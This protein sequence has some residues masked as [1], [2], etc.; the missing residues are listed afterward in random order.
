MA[1]D[2]GIQIDR[3]TD[4]DR[5]TETDRYRLRHRQTERDPPHNRPTVLINKFHTYFETFPHSIIPTIDDHLH[6]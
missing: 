3:Q 6:T 2:R 5:E 1:R 4:R